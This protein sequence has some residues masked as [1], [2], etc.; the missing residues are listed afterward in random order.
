[1]GLFVF[2][3]GQAKKRKG[4]MYMSLITLLLI[5]LGLSMDAFAVSVT[6]GIII[7]NLQL[8]NALKIG[9]FF[10]FFQ[11]FMPLLGWLAGINFSDYITKYDHWIAFI[12]LS[13]IGIKMLREALADD[14]DKS[15]FN[16]LNNKVLLM[17]AIATS[18]D[19]LA[20]GVSFAFL[21]V[22][23]FSS[24]CIIGI[25]TFVLSTLGVYIGKMSGELL[26]KK[27]ELTG[28]IILTLI[29]TKILLEHLNIDIMAAFKWFN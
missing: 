5:A 12:L 29:G 16:P 2:L 4:E 11:G 15:D 23:I 22:S 24:V 1:M 28:G 17:L 26:K 10:G 27:A 8:R 9:I 14:D 18:I 3:N 19:A 25:I 13:F 20:V 21:K 6:S 7:K